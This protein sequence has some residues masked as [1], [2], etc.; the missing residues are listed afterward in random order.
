MSVRNPAV[1]RFKAVTVF[2]RR[3][4]PPTLPYATCLYDEVR[5]GVPTQIRG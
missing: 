3:T 4:S 1:T 5:R 2:V